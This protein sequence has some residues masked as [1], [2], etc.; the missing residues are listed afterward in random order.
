MLIASIFFD[1]FLRAEQ[2]RTNTADLLSHVHIHSFVDKT[3]YYT[4]VLESNNQLNCV[5]SSAYVKQEVLCIFFLKTTPTH[6]KTFK[7]TSWTFF[8]YLALRHVNPIYPVEL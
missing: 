1:L 8:H 5:F 6:P 2:S 7:F 4:L 3:I